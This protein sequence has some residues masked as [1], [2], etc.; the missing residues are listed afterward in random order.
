LALAEAEQ[1]NLVTADMQLL[2]RVRATSWE[3]WA[4]NLSQYIFGP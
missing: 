1:A 2:G 4:I 3:R